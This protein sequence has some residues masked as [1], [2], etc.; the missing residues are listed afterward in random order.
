MQTGTKI[1]LAGHGLLLSWVA[2]GAWFPSEPLPFEVQEVSLI[3]AEEFERLSQVRQAPQVA[4]DASTLQPPEESAAPEVSLPPQQRPEPEPPTPEPLSPPIPDPVVAETPEQPPEPAEPEVPDTAPGVP[5]PPETTA[6]VAPQP[7]VQ[8]QRPVDRVAP[9]PVAPPEPDTAV[10]EIEQPEVAPDVG[11]ETEQEVQEATA[12]EAASDR[13][14]TEEN[15]SDEQTVTAPEQSLRPRGRPI[16]RAAAPE[17]EPEAA[18]TPVETE[19]TQPQ[20]DPSAVE[21]ALAAALSGGA[22]V[23]APEPS[24][25]PL[26]SGEKDALR[27]AVSQCW[28]VGSLSTEAL[29]TTVVVG[30]SLAQDGKPDSGSIRML[31]ST[32]G[33]A[34]AAKQAYEAARRAIIRCGSRGFQLPPEKY[35]Q[36]RD[37]EMTFNPERMRIK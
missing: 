23:E 19:D 20:V 8:Q 5:E 25:P 4:P 22:D 32:G 31:S 21:D 9:V 16:R 29:K 30:V 24:G 26:T 18:P 15:E 34:T 17:P 37:I 13:I 2:F 36:W 3:S 27:V 7:E 14:V 12:P 6:L 10:D 28:N 11:A 1:S 35:A 33:S